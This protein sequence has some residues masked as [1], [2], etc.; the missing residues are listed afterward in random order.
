M[1]KKL[2]EVA[3]LAEVSQVISDYGK[4]VTFLE[5]DDTPHLIWA[6][7]P[8]ESKEL[9]GEGSNL[10]TLTEFLVANDSKITFTIYRG[11]RV[12]IDSVRFR[13]ERFQEIRSG[14]NIV[15]YKCFV[16]R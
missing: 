5:K 13:I 2:D 14:V 11:Q 8:K 16:A 10:E 7:P 15:A 1:S 9:T 12:D 3:L 4:Q 6:S